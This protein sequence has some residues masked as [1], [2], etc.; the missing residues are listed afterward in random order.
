MDGGRKEGEGG[1]EGS[2]TARMSPTGPRRVVSVQRD[3]DTLQERHIGLGWDI[4]A[5]LFLPPLRVHVW[6]ISGITVLS[7]ISLP[8]K[9]F[10]NMS[11]TSC[12]NWCVG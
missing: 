9:P 1:E 12:W 3:D 8:C 2:E 6:Y 4:L 7:C 10:I 11:V 5:T